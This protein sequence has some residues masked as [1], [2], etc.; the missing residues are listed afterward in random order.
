MHVYVFESVH[1]SQ[2]LACANIAAEKKSTQKN[3]YFSQHHSPA[4][5]CGNIYC[6]INK[7]D[8]E[9]ISLLKYVLCLSM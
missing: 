5:K 1:L 3:D 6:K 2:F 4:D 7:I 9:I 8:E